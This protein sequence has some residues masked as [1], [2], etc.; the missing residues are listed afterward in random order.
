ML[1]FARSEV[2]HRLV[3]HIDPHLGLRVSLDAGEEFCQEFITHHYWQHE[4]VQL[5]VL[6]DVGKERGDDHAETIAGNGPGGMLAARA[7]TE[8]LACHQNLMHTFAGC[9]A[10]VGLVEDE[11]LLR[12][13]LLVVAP[14]AE[15]VVAEEALVPRRGFQ[16]A[17]RNDLVG[18]DILQRKRNAQ[19]IG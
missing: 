18:I 15:Q 1:R 5:V 17:G 12:L 11:V 13:A 10:V 7:R 16:E 2:G 14:V 19:W 4:V 3:G 8:V 9:L 6:V